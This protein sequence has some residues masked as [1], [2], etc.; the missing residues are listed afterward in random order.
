M[1]KELVQLYSLEKNY[2]DAILLQTEIINQSSF[3]A[4]ALFERAQLYDLTNQ[5]E[6]AIA[7]LTSAQYHLTNIPDH[8]KVVE[9]IMLLKHSIDYMLEDLSEK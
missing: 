6:L 3:K 5:P 2:G 4:R 1:Q 9:S 8:K 7:D